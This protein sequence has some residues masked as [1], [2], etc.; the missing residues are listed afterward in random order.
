MP[1]YTAALP[2][3][4]PVLESD[5]AEQLASPCSPK[6]AEEE[7]VGVALG[8]TVAALGLSN[9]VQQYAISLT[10]CNVTVEGTTHQNFNTHMHGT[11]THTHTQT[12]TRARVRTHLCILYISNITLYSNLSLL[13]AHAI[14]QYML[15]MRFSPAV[16]RAQ[17]TTAMGRT[18]L[19]TR[20]LACWMGPL[21]RK[22]WRR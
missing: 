10:I 21:L 22:S 18:W 13:R 4:G 3:H 19:P 16:N 8:A 15:G 9:K 20:S 1:R 14:R 2:I 6:Q 12:H 11:H 5:V 7:G 17:M